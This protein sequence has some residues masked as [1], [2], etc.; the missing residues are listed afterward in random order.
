MSRPLQIFCASYK[1]H[2]KLSAMIE[3]VIA[4]GYD[5]E[6]FVG[7]GDLGTV[8]LCE[9]LR[10]RFGGRVDCVYDSRDN[11]LVGCTAPLNHVVDRLVTRDAIF[12]TDD[13]MFEKDCLH[14]AMASLDRHFPDGDG[15]IGIANTSI[16]GD[17][18]LAYPLYGRTFQQRFRRVMGGPLFFPGYFHL[19]NDAEIGRTIRALGCW[20]LETRARVYHAHPLYGGTMDATHS[21][22]LTFSGH[23]QNVWNA[24]C[25]KGLLWGIDEEEVASPDPTGLKRSA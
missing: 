6:V 7:A 1:R 20:R 9:R 13:L 16:E 5:A 14:E 23:D 24:R 15:V 22:A 18:P 12:C 10:A 11:R 25:A 2:E 8:E 17:Y 21:H 19:Y 4:T 3:S